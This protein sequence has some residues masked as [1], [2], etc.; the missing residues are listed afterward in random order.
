MFQVHKVLGGSPA[1]RDGR[2]Q[3]GDRILS[4]NGRS[5]KGLTH[6][7]ALLILK[8]CKITGVIDINVIITFLLRRHLDLRLC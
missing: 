1:E 6:R 5:M 4:I 3:K 8:V 2:M 7:E